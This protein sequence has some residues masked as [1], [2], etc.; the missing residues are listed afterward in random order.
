MSVDHIQEY[1]RLSLVAHCTCHVSKRKQYI[2]WLFH[3]S[4]FDPYGPPGGGRPIITYRDLDAPRD[5]DEFWREKR[6]RNS[7]PRKK[8]PNPEKLKSFPVFLKPFPPHHRQEQQLLLN[9]F[10]C[11]HWYKVLRYFFSVLVSSRPYNTKYYYGKLL[12]PV[13]A[14]G[15]TTAH[16]RNTKQIWKWI[17]H[18]NKERSLEYSNEANILTQSYFI[19]LVDPFHRL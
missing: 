16:W 7:L 11:A 1:F 15:N 17:L 19:S 8:K 9:F 14:P 4:R 6:R 12:F 10:C 2:F 13:P 18:A 3:H 5:A